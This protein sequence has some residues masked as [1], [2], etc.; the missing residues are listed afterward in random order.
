MKNVLLIFSILTLI[1]CAPPPTPKKMHQ[2][3]GETSKLSQKNKNYHLSS[4]K[5][6][7][8]DAT[9]SKENSTVNIDFYEDYTTME[10]KLTLVPQN[11]PSGSCFTSWKFSLNTDGS[12]FNSISASCE[13]TSKS[14]KKECKATYSLDSQKLLFKYEG[15]ICDGDNL[16][17]NYKYNQK[18]NTK[19]ILYINKYVSIPLIKETFFCD[20]KI[21]IP[22]GYI[23][24]GLENNLLTKESNTIYTYKGKCPTESQYDI[25]RYSPEKVTWKA[26]TEI[27]VEYPSKFTNNIKITFPRY[28]NGGKINK[29][30]Y[31]ISSTTGES[32]NEENIIY[33]YAYY[34]VDIPAKNKEKVAMVLNTNFTNK[35]TEEF[36]VYIPEIYYDISLTEIDQEII[37]KAKEIINEDSD[38]PNYY[39]IGQF[40]NNYLTY[41]LSYSGKD[42]TVK[43]IY[44]QKKG[45]CE[46]Y[47]KLYNAMLNAIGIKAINISGWAFQ[48]NETSGNNKTVG[49]AW[50][51][52]LIDGK[53]KELDST[54]GLFEGIPAGHILKNIYT[55]RYYF[56]HYENSNEISFGQNREI[57]MISILQ[58]S[59]DDDNNND[60]NSGNNKSDDKTDNK[61]DENE[62]ES[63]DDYIGKIN[64]SSYKTPS[65]LIILLFFFHI[66]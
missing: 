11:L 41:D 54:W 56:N 9:L 5:R 50:T 40:V 24:L 37:D 17:V 21:T 25:I 2:V 18:E 34:Q 52:A 61:N 19:E 35:L 47:T 55:D 53:W 1:A 12:T 26:K 49:H 15:N 13:I 29:S 6:V 27:Y 3:V 62:D 42:L 45:V 22:E 38:K 48:G 7:G 58:N 65:L 60:D 31:N 33:H 23:N 64:N 8:S 16:I 43:Q 14:S 20:Y 36:D 66:L 32:Y 39:K 4:K 28:Y 59:S 57:Q 44:D 30:Y 10:N 46:H 63:I 51:A